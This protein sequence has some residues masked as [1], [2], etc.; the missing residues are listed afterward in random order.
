M[1]EPW[2]QWYPHDIDSWQGSG[3][4]QALSDT[5][6]RA[7][8]NILQDMWKQEDCSLPCDQ[9]VLRKAS[10]VAERWEHCREEVMDYFNRNEDGS[11]TSFVLRGKWLKAKEVYEARQ[12]AAKKTN[13]VKHGEPSKASRSAEQSVT[14]ASRSADTR[15]LTLTTTKTTTKKEQKTSLRQ[16]QSDPRHVPFKLAC[17]TYAT[18]KKVPFVW[19]GGEAKILAAL[20]AASPELPLGI[21]QTCLN[22][23]AKSQVPHG[24]RPREWLGTILKY[25][26]G[27][28][29][30]Y[31]K[32]Q[33]A[34]NGTYKG[35]T[36]YSVDAATRAIEAIE[37]RH[38]TNGAGDS[39]AGEVGLGGLPGA[40]ERPGEVRTGGSGRGDE[41]VVLEATR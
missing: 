33:G 15:T 29:D 19:D 24:E 31:G 37:N 26:E 11:I 4:I 14:V 28:L 20:L 17:E 2:N 36:G 1:A 38:A 34:G 25:T 7:V 41:G 32:P 21:F 22:H 13:E 9:K 3:N 12:K 10:R 40:L 5:A 6:Y 16:A 35:K 18:Y 8:H 27:P 30:Q 39:E 23:R